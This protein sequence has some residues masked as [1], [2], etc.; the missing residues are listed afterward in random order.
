MHGA[1][2]YRGAALVQWSGPCGVL[3]SAH[4]AGALRFAGLPERAGIDRVIAARSKIE[5]RFLIAAICPKLEGL[6]S[7][8]P[9]NNRKREI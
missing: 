2:R 3:N 8:P 6:R 4:A 9:R 7:G 1:T 5:I